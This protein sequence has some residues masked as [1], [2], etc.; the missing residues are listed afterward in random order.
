MPRK[1]Y[2]NTGPTTCRFCN[3]KF[4]ANR[5]YLC[6]FKYE[7]NARCKRLL[8]EGFEYPEPQLP[9]KRTY[10]NVDNVELPSSQDNDDLQCKEKGRRYVLRFVIFEYFVPKVFF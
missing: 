6:H 5:Y 7:V 10:D 9:Q 3:K 4:T 2:G 8:D 1:K